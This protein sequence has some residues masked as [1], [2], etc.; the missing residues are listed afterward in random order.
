MTH[1]APQRLFFSVV[2]LAGVYLRC[3]RA[4]FFAVVLVVESVLFYV[5]SDQVTSF[6]QRKT[7]GKFI[8]GKRGRAYESMNINC[9]TRRKG[10]RVKRMYQMKK[11]LMFLLPLVLIHKKLRNSTLSANGAQITHKESR[12]RI[13]NDTRH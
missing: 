7:A 6:S 1:T 10:D 5:L 12:K 13:K 2:F 9:L 4:C 11:C 8:F 3:L